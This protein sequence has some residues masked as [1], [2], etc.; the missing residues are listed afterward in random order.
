LTYSGLEDFGGQIDTDGISKANHALMF[1]CQS[2]ADNLVQPI[3]MFASKG[4]VKG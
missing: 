3:A 4:P 1:M 2:L